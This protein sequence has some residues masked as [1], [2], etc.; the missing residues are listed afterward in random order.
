MEIKQLKVGYIRTNCY[1]L[2]NEKDAIIIDPGAEYEKIKEEIKELN[3]QAILVTHY[4]F[5]H[6][7][8]LPHFK[9]IKTYDYKQVN[10]KIKIKNFEFEIIETKGHTSDSVSFYFE[11][12]KMMFVGDFIFQNT[13]GRTDLETSNM[14]DMKKNI[15]KIKKYPKEIKIYPGH[16]NTTI[17]S[18]EIMNNPF[19]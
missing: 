6:V 9:N 17:L 19:F 11:K 10:K 16:G 8:T 7:G 18:E 14:N 3:V 12:E 15:N 2:I 1:I 4:H 13:I 5:D